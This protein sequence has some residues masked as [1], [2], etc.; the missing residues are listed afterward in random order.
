MDRSGLAGW[1][2]LLCVFAVVQFVP[3]QIGCNAAHVESQN[4]ESLGPG[5]SFDIPSEHLP[6]LRWNRK[7]HQVSALALLQGK[8]ECQHLQILFVLVQYRTLGDVCYSVICSMQ[9]DVE[10]NVSPKRKDP[11]NGFKVYNGS[12]Q[13]GSRSYWAASI[14]TGYPSMIIGIAWIFGLLLISTVRC[15]CCIQGE[16][17]ISGPAVLC[18]VCCLLHRLLAIH[19]RCLLFHISFGQF[20]RG[21]WVCPG[22]IPPKSCDVLAGLPPKNLQL[23]HGLEMVQASAW[24]VFVPRTSS[25]LSIGYIHSV[26][27]S[28]IHRRT[29]VGINC[30]EGVQASCTDCERAI[31]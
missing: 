20:S 5:W 7:L 6:G 22:W 31:Q 30:V 29:T 2:T 23:F 8:L 13:L 28:C 25:A 12:L 9:T 4:F 14:W 26:C 27:E 24:G 11:L 21:P 17:W 15:V 10:L 3:N 19:L 18:N 1:P 16:V